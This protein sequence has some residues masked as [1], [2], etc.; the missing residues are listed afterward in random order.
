M[1]N[2]T[3]LKL[4]IALCVTS[5]IGSA[6]GYIHAA[7]GT[8]PNFIEKEPLK[9]PFIQISTQEQTNTSKSYILKDNNGIVTLY[10]KSDGQTPII[11]KKYDVYVSTLPKADRVALETGIEI[12]TLSDALELV[13]GYLE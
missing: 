7:R 3:V 1:N 4:G 9:T 12:S 11:Y 2:R 6:S 8:S 10:V 5:F 13:E